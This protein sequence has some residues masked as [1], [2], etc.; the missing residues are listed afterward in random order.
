MRSR[1]TCREKYVSPSSLATIGKYSPV[2]GSTRFLIESK[3]R[4]IVLGCLPVTADSSSIRAGPCCNT[5][6]TC[7]ADLPKPAHLKTSWLDIVTHFLTLGVFGECV[8][9]FKLPS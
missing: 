4:S 2:R 3:A 5:N 8:T 7:P 6:H 1:S 9:M